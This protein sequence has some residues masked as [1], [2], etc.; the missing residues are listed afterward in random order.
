MDSL[1]PQDNRSELQN[2]LTAD[3]SSLFYILVHTFSSLSS[4]TTHP[5]GCYIISDCRTI[6]PGPTCRVELLT[7]AN[8]SLHTAATTGLIVIRRLPIGDRSRMESEIRMRQVEVRVTIITTT[9]H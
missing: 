3:G 1:N 7:W 8:H 6:L 9:R 4:F 5:S 2:L